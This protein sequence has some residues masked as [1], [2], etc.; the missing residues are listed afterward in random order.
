MMNREYQRDQQREPRREKDVGQIIRYLTSVFNQAIYSLERPAWSK[1]KG[2]N[3][4]YV[5][6]RDFAYL[7]N[8][9]VQGPKCMLQHN[10]TLC[11]EFIDQTVQEVSR[12]G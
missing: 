6:T 9:L 4:A 8:E 3:A 2:S 10:I 1:E 12:R 11:N 7:L 5:L